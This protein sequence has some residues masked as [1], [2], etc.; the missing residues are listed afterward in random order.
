MSTSSCRT[1]VP[2]HTILR[3]S[4]VLWH[5]SWVGGLLPSIQ[6]GLLLGHG[7]LWMSTGPCLL[8]LQLDCSAWWLSIACQPHYMGTSMTQW[9]WTWTESLLPPTQ[10]GLSVILTVP[11]LPVWCTIWTWQHWSYEPPYPGTLATYNSDITGAWAPCTWIS[12]II[13]GHTSQISHV[14]GKSEGPKF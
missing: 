3:T 8:S 6:Y 5:C 2:N 4:V 9:P 7:W 14:H 12:R 10:Y 13:G 1:A 11:Q